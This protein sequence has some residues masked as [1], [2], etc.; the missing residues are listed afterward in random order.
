[1]STFRYSAYDPEGKLKKGSVEAVS[2]EAAMKELGLRGLVP[3]EVKEESRKG[4]GR[5]KK[6]SLQGHVLFCRSLASYLKSGLPITEALELLKDQAPDRRLGE[7]YASLLDNVHG[8]RRLAA[9]MGSLGTFRPGLVGMIESGENSGSL[10]DVLSRAAKVYRSEMVLKRKVQSAM[11]YPLVMLVVGMGVIGF[12]LG[13]VVPRLSALF[14]DLGQALPLPTRVLLTLSGAVQTLWIPLLLVL[15]LCFWMGKRRNWGARMPFV[16]QTR[17]KVTLSLVFS[18]LATLVGSGIPLTQSL[19]MVA[20]MDP[21]PERW[22]EVSK[23][24][25]EGYRFAQA[26]ERQGSFPK[27]VVYLVRV[28]EMGSELEDALERVAET[29]W[30]VAES[31][32]ERLAN[33]IEPVM[34]LFLGGAVGFVVVAI[35]L[36]I[37]DL[38][39]LVK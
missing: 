37:F 12:L 8:G 1:M 5:V 34:I 15:I 28:G 22:H 2:S 33:L 25:K 23:G 4:T 10:V 11:I 29:N 31:D 20:P 3:V 18:H 13:Y 17:E 6:L 36:P 39:G 30:E 7:A 26:M 16:R 21:S 24:V 38:S 35:L 19:Q 14:Q 9:A 27:E 32:M